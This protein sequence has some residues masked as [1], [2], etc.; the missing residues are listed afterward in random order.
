M[1]YPKI[2]THHE[3]DPAAMRLW[4]SETLQ[5]MAGTDTFIQSYP[6]VTMQLARKLFFVLESMFPVLNREEDFITRLHNQ[7]VKPA[8]AFAIRMQTSSAKYTLLP[9]LSG[10]D[11]PSKGVVS[12]H[13]ICS[14]KL[15]DVKSGRTIRDE[16]SVVAKPDGSI[17]EVVMIVAP[18]LFR[19][20]PAEK[21]A[22][23][24]HNAV[25]LVELDKPLIKRRKATAKSLQ[26]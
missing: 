25:W 1:N 11:V 15:I 7:V 3:T 16:H 6:I 24:I 18:S 14:C 17:G 13:N 12:V 26:G 5:S 2:L 21:E 20:E 10:T 9:D 19:Q 4:R 22:I 23:R 8:T